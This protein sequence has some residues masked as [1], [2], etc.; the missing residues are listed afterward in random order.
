MK[1]VAVPLSPAPAA[2]TVTVG[3]IE[4]GKPIAPKFAYCM[5]DGKGKTSHGGNI[6]PEIRWSGAPE[7]TKSFAVIV[8][9]KDVPKTFELANKEGKSI[10][11]AFPRRDF[12]HWVLA[13]IP[14]HI[15]RIAEGQDSTGIAAGGKKPGKTAYGI[16]GHNDYSNTNGGYDGCCPPWNDER[17]H[18]YHFMVCA[19]DVES[20]NLPGNFGGVEAMAAIK[21]HL[22]AQGEIVGTYTNNPNLLK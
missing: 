6:N 10:P 21:R 16:N 18:H 7:G 9:D 4:H 11:A 1:N 5:P 8:V 14:A 3:G 2:L 12:Y 20:L 22:L 15:T 17:L 19:L 13:D